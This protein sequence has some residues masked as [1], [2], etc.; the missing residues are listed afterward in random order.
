MY[1]K[2]INKLN[3]ENI[4]AIV[5]LCSHNGGAF[6]YSQIISILDQTEQIQRLCV[7]DFN[8]TDNTISEIYRAKDYCA[9]NE[10]DVCIDIEV[11][12]SAPGVNQS[13]ITALKCVSKFIKSNDWLYVCDQDDI[14]KKDK[15]LNVMQYIK[16]QRNAIEPILLHH[17]V[18][19]VDANLKR[20]GNSY[21]DDSQVLVLKKLNQPAKYYGLVI[22]HTICMNSCAVHTLSGLSQYE[23]IA[24]YD[25]FWGALIEAV[26]KRIF[27]PETLSLYRQHSNNLVGARWRN[28]SIT[29]KLHDTAATT[30]VAVLQCTLL[31]YEIS[32]LLVSSNRRVDEE[33]KNRE[34]EYE[35]T[36][37]TL[38]KIKLLMK[39]IIIKIIIDLTV[40]LFKIYTSAHRFEHRE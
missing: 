27:I 40:P 15:H 4:N 13:F 6:I 2:N 25:W 14:W 21:Y 23:Q 9:S 5:M 19:I 37:T 30:L 24:M 18:E 7:Y 11:F 1:Q 16:S 17:D 26:G 29:Q 35:K 28:K 36:Y 32:R 31:E 22:G 20:I 8:S 38:L 39:P 33:A 12:A 34:V 10:I 3:S